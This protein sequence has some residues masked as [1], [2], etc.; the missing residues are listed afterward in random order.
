[1]NEQ[2]LPKE[3]ENLP[4]VPLLLDSTGKPIRVLTR[5]ERERASKDWDEE[6]MCD[7]RIEETERV[8]KITAAQL[9][10]VFS[11]DKPAF[12]E[13]VPDFTAS[14]A[15]DL[16]PGV[17]FAKAGGLECI[18]NREAVAKELNLPAGADVDSIVRKKLETGTYG[19]L[20]GYGMDTMLERPCIYVK[21]N[22]DGRFVFGFM[23][24]P[25]R[26]VATRYALQRFADFKREFPQ[27]EWSYA[28]L[29]LPA[30]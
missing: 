20:L 18:Y 17:H 24:S 7:K 13:T 3:G 29:P 4:G 14:F 1:M 2:K 16:P 25:D 9:N 10:A 6:F 21:I 28:L 30:P 27:S 12:L 8:A 26:Q 19:K 22:R 15:E 11:G 5:E 23:T